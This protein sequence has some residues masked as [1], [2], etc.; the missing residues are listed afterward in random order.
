VDSHR[1]VWLLVVATIPTAL[2]GYVG[3]AL[4]PRV[5][6]D[7]HHLGPRPT[8]TAAMVRY[9]LV[10]WASTL[11]YQAAQFAMPVIVLVHVDADRNASF[12]VAWGVAALACY[13]PTAIGRTCAARCAWPSSSRED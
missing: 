7:R 2:S 6:G 4:L 5:T 10:N 8:T 1:S 11:T 9:S 13:V 12:Y 3:L